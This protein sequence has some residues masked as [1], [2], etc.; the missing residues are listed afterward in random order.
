MIFSLGTLV[1]AVNL[2]E[3]NTSL[4]TP[5]SPTGVPGP[6]ESS[7]KSTRLWAELHRL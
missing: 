1:P 3:G 7:P 4:T 6:G 2:S 5:E